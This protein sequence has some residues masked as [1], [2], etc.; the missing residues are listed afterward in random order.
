MN[1]FCVHKNRESHATVHKANYIKACFLTKNSIQ[2]SF[3]CDIQ[4]FGFEIGF[5]VN[6]ETLLLL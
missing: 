5:T 4:L 2:E 6:I 3:I 1:L